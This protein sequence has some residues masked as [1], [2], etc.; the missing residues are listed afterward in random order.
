M[1]EKLKLCRNLL[2]IQEM[3]I[4]FSDDN[5]SGYYMMGMYN[6]ME[7]LMSVLED[8]KPQFCSMLM[9]Q[10]AEGVDGEMEGEE[11]EA[12]KIDLRTIPG[13]IK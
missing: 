5:T 1:E 3:N 11:C 7:L 12:C 9:E 8:R 4:N 13:K 10:E 6:G 2:E